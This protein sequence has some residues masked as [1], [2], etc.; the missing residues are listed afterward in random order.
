MLQQCKFD[1]RSLL[2]LCGRHHSMVTVSPSRSVLAATPSLPNS[3]NNAYTLPR[4][5]STLE[6]SPGDHLPSLGHLQKGRSP[7]GHPFATLHI[8]VAPIAFSHSG[9]LWS[10]HQSPAQDSFS[11]LSLPTTTKS[12]DSSRTHPTFSPP[13][14][15]LQVQ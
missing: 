1:S 6:P 15:P 5:T 13:N 4:A 12:G 14:V 10:S 2:L 8:F 11:Q 7:T 3:R 9:G